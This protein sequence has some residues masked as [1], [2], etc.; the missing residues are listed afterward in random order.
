MKILKQLLVTACVLF[1]LCA[2]ASGWNYILNDDSRSYTRLTMHQLYENAGK[3][4]TLFIGSSHCYRS[5]VPE[6]I[7]RGMN[8]HSFNAGTSSQRMDGSL[9]LLKEAGSMN[10]LK[11]VYLEVYYAVADSQD[12]QERTEMTQTYIISDYMRPSLNK[13][14]FLFS[15][16]E[17]EYWINGLLPARRYWNK[18]FEPEYIRKTIENKQ[19]GNYRNYRFPIRPEDTEYYKERGFVAS[20]GTVAENVMINEKAYGRIETGDQI[21]TDSDW[22]SCLQEIISYCKDNH[23]RL[24]FVISPEPEWTLAGKGNYQEYHDFIAGI[25]EENGIRFLDFNLCRNDV[26]NTNDRRLFKDTD[27]LNTAGAQQFS[28]LF[29]S[30]ETGRLDEKDIFFVSYDEKIR[31][32]SNPFYGLAGGIKVQNGKRKLYS[33]IT[34]AEG[35]EYRI[36]FND[37]SG[38]MRMVQNYNGTGKFSLSCRD[39]GTLNISWRKAGEKEDEGSADIKI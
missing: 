9:A 14:Q 2:S 3:T 18:F 13:Y 6:V 31:T 28:R 34:G 30:L 24:T 37:R 38:N 25:A 5:F 15:A 36:I 4:D 23:I 10:V 29:S 12:Y 32:D 16:C 22:Y 27:H 17:K 33:V 26:F 35:Y 11:Q 19:N 7:D 1:L 8:V 20:S 39:T 21:S